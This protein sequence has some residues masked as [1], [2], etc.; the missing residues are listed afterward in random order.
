MGVNQD[1]QSWY[2]CPTA[3]VNICILCADN[4]PRQQRSDNKKNNNIQISSEDCSET[5][6]AVH[7]HCR[8]LSV[9]AGCVDG[10]GGVGFHQGAPP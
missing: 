1:T 8:R 3:G 7:E 4:K 5:S 6:G 9:P 10:D 2:K